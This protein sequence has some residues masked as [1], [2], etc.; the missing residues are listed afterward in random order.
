[1]SVR[2]LTKVFQHSEAT[3][4]ARLVLLA[5]ADSASDDGVTWIGQDEIA[6]K[7]K[8]VNSTARRCIGELEDAGEVET[9]KAQ[10]GRRRINVYRVKMPGLSEPAY[11]RLPFELSEPFSTTADIERSSGDDD[12]RSTPMT[13]AD[14]EPL[15]ARGSLLNRKENRNEGANAPSTEAPPALVKIDGRD[16]AFDTLAAVCGCSD[17]NAVR[18]VGMALNGTQG[19]TGIRQLAWD[20]LTEPA[21]ILYLNDDPGM[22]EHYL[23]ST[24]Q[25][26]ANAYRGAMA[27]A[28]LTPLAL[29]KWWGRVENLAGREGLSPDEIERV[30]DA[31]A[32]ESGR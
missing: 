20:E 15:R 28:M 2:V 22:F 1:M 29:A 19:T 13:T 26:R 25:R 30:A 18:Q 31:A 10:R 4:A 3:L 6:A 21:R 24:I 14:L 5:L 17:R 23:S 7:A 11:D 8:V 16:I 32:A 12:R 27:G 9:R